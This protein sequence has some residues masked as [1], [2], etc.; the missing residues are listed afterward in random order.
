M[1]RKSLQRVQ[2]QLAGGLAVNGGVPIQLHA[3]VEPGGLPDAEHVPGPALVGE[4]LLGAVVAQRA[5]EHFC[6][7]AAGEAAARAERAVR[8]TADDAGILA[9]SDDRGKGM[10]RRDVGIRAFRGGEAFGGVAAQ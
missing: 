2:S 8:V 6:K 3:P 10:I 4:T 7:G 1:D 9:V 5:Q